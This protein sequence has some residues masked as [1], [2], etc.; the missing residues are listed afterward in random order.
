[1]HG[2][3]TLHLTNETEQNRSIIQNSYR[4]CKANVSGDAYTRT[5]DD[6]TAGQ[7]GVV[8]C[9]EDFGA[10]SKTHS[11]YIRVLKTYC[12]ESGIVFNREKFVFAQNSVDFAGGHKRREQTPRKGYRSHS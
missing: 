2:T 7:P 10:I 4:H 5:F 12:G 6:I 3:A 9:I 1:M 11:A 8:R